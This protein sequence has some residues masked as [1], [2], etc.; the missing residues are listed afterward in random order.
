MPANWEAV[1]DRHARLR[2]VGIALFWFGVAAFALNLG[3]AVTGRASFARVL[4]GVAAMGFSLGA[5]GTNNDTALHAMA[6]LAKRDL[7]PARFAGEWAHELATR[8]DKAKH[9]HAA[10]KMAL[11]MP[12]AALLVVAWAIWRGA[13]AWGLV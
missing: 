4:L 5:F 9:P 1:A 10:P 8:P 12:V 11:V 6:E 3:A 13:G 2:W 7:L